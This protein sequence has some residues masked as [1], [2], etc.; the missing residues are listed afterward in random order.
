VTHVPADRLRADFGLDEKE[1]R[2]L[3]SELPERIGRAAHGVAISRFAEFLALA[4]AN[5]EHALRGNARQFAQQQGRARLSRKILQ[6]FADGALRDLIG[7]PRRRRE[8]ATR[9]VLEYPEHGAAF[10]SLGS[11]RPYAKVHSESIA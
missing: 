11:D 4:E 5:Q 7:A 1:H 9:V 6:R 2:V 8:F 3:D 10:Y